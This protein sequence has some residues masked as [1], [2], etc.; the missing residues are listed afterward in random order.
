MTSTQNNYDEQGPWFFPRHDIDPKDKDEAWARSY[1]WA[2]WHDFTAAVPKSVFYNSYDKYEQYRLYALSKQPINVY[3]ELMGIDEEQKDTFMPIDWTAPAFVS[4]YRSIAISRLV[5]QEYGIVCTPIDPTAKG[6]LAKLYAKLKAK[7]AVRQMMQQQNPE[8]A[9]HPAVQP[10]G[11][12]PWDEE[13]L[14]MRIDFGEQFNRAKDAEEAIA[15]AFY[16]NGVKEV[17][18]KWFEDFFDCGVAGY[19]EGLDDHSRPYFRFI[20]PECIV[21]NYCKFKDFRDLQHAGEVID[22]SIT[23]LATK[24]KSDGTPIFT[25]EQLLDL[26]TNVAGKWNN[27]SFVSRSTSYYKGYDHF[28]CKV[29]QLEF[30]SYND[31]VWKDSTNWNGNITFKESKYSNLNRDVPNT[32][33]NT[34]YTS[35]KIKVVYKINWVVGTNYSY[36]FELKKNQ[37][38][39][40][41]PKKMGETELSYRFYAPNFY[42]MRAQGQMEKLIPFI[43]QCC[44]TWYRIQN[45]KARMVPSG[46]WIDLA[47][48]EQVALSKGGENMTSKQL[49]NMFFQSGILAGRSDLM[50]DINNPNYKPIIPIENSVAQ[51]L[52]GLYQDLEMNI[53]KIEGICGFNAVTM[54]GDTRRTPVPGVESANVS[55]DNALFEMANGERF[56]L[57]KLAEDMVKRIQQSVKLT[58]YEGYAPA[59]N[60][61]TLQF[62]SV[63]KDLPL[64][65]YGIMTEERP[66][67]NERQFLIQNSQ[68]DRAAGFLDTS[69]MMILLNTYNFK[70][71]QE[72]IAL[73][74]KK[75]KQAQAAEKQAITAQ[76]IQ[77]QQ[78]SAQV[79]GQIQMQLEQMKEQSAMELANVTGRFNTIIA[80]IKAKQLA[81]AAEWKTQMEL[82]QHIIP[83][84]QQSEQAAAQ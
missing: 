42:Q 50:G 78:Q 47:A 40:V 22:V 38:R 15:L 63:S 69:D 51:E 64:R 53:N 29:L 84:A 2:A 46:W 76:T 56:L 13:E 72:M 12:E 79:S 54:G 39:S 6:E 37:K 27:P 70:Q 7:I 71:A 14:Q 31:I 35:K 73:K 16:E 8:L 21:T 62:I 19:Y 66:T 61:S 41:N 1:A 52:A 55:T 5:Q 65:D 81:Q 33:K 25:D 24:T 45:F 43:D 18:K 49:I 67:D 30:F 68:Q 77:G 20:D 75:N 26:G 48:L 57:E 82:I 4:K 17:R 58:G 59:L 10:A 44:L 80:E 74:V 36:G 3:R 34:K 9:Q 23:D 28:K 83:P 60:K 32:E 11:N